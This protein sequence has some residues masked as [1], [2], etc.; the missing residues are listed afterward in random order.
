MP[1][2]WQ[3]QSIRPPGDGILGQ[4][5]LSGSI[6][7][8]AVTDG[9]RISFTNP[10]TLNGIEP[11][12]FIRVRNLPAGAVI[13]LPQQGL[14]GQIVLNSNA[15]TIGSPPTAPTPGDALAYWSGAIQL[16]TPKNAVS[17][18]ADDDEILSAADLAPAYGYVSMELGGGA[19]GLVP[20]QYYAADSMPNRPSGQAGL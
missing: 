18:S 10:S 15:A 17:L 4:Q 9:S 8:E 11:G 3:T 7:A 14:R 12:S 20:Y 13:E 2:L 6:T 5:G 1:T 19:A 16:S